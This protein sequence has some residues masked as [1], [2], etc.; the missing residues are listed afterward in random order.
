MNLSAKLILWHLEKEY[1]L[2]ASG[3]LSSE[4]YLK[5]AMHYERESTFE[6]GIIY[7]VDQP[8]FHVPSH[9]LSHSL[10]LLVGDSF[11]IQVKDYPNVCRIQDASAPEVQNSICQIFHR[12]SEWNQALFESRLT[13]S[14]IQNLL[15][16]SRSVIS[17]PILVISMDFVIIA[18]NGDLFSELLGSTLGSTAETADVILALKQDKNYEEA[19]HRIGYFYYP[20]NNITFPSLCVNIRKF[21]QT[22]YRLMI[23]QGELPLDDTFGFVLEY[24]ARMISHSLSTTLVDSHDVLHHFHQI[25][26]TLLTDSSADY[27]EISQQLS[28]HGWLSSHYYYCI[29]IQ[30]GALDYKNLTLRS[31]CGYLE[32]T[33]PS[34]CA[35]EHK[36]NVILYINLNL[37]RMAENDIDQKLAG[38]IRDSF[39]TGGCSRKIMGHFNFHR[40]YVQASIALQSGSRKNPQQW[41]HH[42]NDIA[43][44]YLLEQTTKKLPAYMVCHEKLLTLKYKS[45]ENNNQLYQTLR[46]YLENHSN[47]TQTARELFIH[48]ST[49]LYRLDRIHEIM[50]TD[51]ADPDEILYLLLSFRLMEL[52]EQQQ[53]DSL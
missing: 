40:M 30:P 4:P 25:F 43:L 32:N 22:V 39:L 36:G 31:I 34:S 17:N 26:R 8:D 1:Q 21:D 19:Y 5:Y 18:S 29:L 13:N 10:F 52:E 44:T 48:R 9:R 42:F 33:I 35:V 41:I 53:T 15:D 20:G 50:Q 45:E 3:K 11:S 2:T 6:N 47:V 37:C 27:V 23:T 12:Y 28:L 49:L 24:L 46:C 16:L 51:Y 14:S 38:F 7:I